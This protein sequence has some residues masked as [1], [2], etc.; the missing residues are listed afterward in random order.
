MPAPS[1]VVVIGIEIDFASVVRNAIAVSPPLITGFDV[2]F[3]VRTSVLGMVEEA[4]VPAGATMTDIR[5]QVN[6]VVGR[7]DPALGKPR[8]AGAG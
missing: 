4:S 8:P 1:A 3:A 7:E 5:H 6:T 2:T